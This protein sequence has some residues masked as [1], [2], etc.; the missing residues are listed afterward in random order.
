MRI[1]P[2]STAT[3]AQ[4]NSAPPLATPW[5]TRLGWLVCL[6][7]MSLM[8]VRHRV[9]AHFRCRFDS[10]S[11]AATRRESRRDALLVPGPVFVIPLPIR[12]PYYK[13]I[14]RGLEAGC[15]QLRVTKNGISATP[16]KSWHQWWDKVCTPMSPTPLA[17]A[18]WV[19]VPATGRRLPWG[20]TTPRTHKGAWGAISTNSQRRTRVTCGGG[21]LG[22]HSDNTSDQLV[23]HARALTLALFC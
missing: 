5:A 8:D 1:S 4:G 22:I 20:Q 6:L 15:R 11:L 23:S 17:T 3:L 9:E 18:A 16:A 19:L 10:Y 21:K 13:G 14:P 7:T 2:P 12:P